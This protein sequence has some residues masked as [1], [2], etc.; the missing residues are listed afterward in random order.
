MTVPGSRNIRLK[1]KRAAVLLACYNKTYIKKIL[2]DD[3]HLFRLQNLFSLND[4]P[5]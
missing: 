3:E 4:P 1:N 5:T 2:R